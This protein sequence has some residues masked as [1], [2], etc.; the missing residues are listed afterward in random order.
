MTDEPITA[1]AAARAATELTKAISDAREAYEFV[2]NSYTY[3]CLS[4]CL[5]A[6]AAL[7]VL[8]ANLTN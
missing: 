1:R 8:R 3:A 4:A 6:D 5:A 7:E 2:P